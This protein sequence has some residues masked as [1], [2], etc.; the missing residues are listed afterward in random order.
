MRIGQTIVVKQNAN[1]SEL[2]RAIEAIIPA[3]TKQAAS[4]ANRY[5]GKNEAETCKK[6]FDYLKNNIN[7]KA[8]GT[9]QAVRLPSGLMRTAQGDCKSYSVFTSAIL[10]N[11]GIPHKLV[12]ASYDPKDPTPTHI[13]VMT[14]SGCIIDAVYG[15]FNAEKKATYKKYK[16]MNIS[17]IA[18]MNKRRRIGNMGRY[19]TG[20]S[21]G[22]GAVTTG[23]TWAKN[24]GIWNTI[25]NGVKLNFYKNLVL[26]P[27]IG[28]REIIKALLRKNSG[29]FANAL[30]KVYEIARANNNTDEFR[31][32]RAM[33]L[34]WLQ[35]GGNPDDLRVAFQEGN[36]KT[37]TGAK[38]NEVLKKAK[39]GQ[40]ISVG[41]AIA[42][43]VS[44]LFGKK[45]D[46]STGKVIG[47]TGAEELPV[48]LAT[49]PVWLPILREVVA[50]LGGSFNVGGAQ[51]A[52]GENV[53]SQ[54]GGQG[55]EGTQSKFA[56]S[57]LL[58]VL[59]IGG[60]AAAYFILKPTKK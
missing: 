37:P 27:Y 40:S 2:Q 57:G 51:P 24:L 29:G 4:I 3:A 56:Q 22:I 50:I 47:A 25:P 21:C 1:N 46:P 9:N 39:A 55:G 23:E 13:Y 60:A 18:G 20:G 19:G 58:P 44:A 16:D 17:Y 54:G 31:K 36:S 41:E 15:K 32:Y 8:D 43:A 53:D 14:K 7:Y 35:K 5:K 33:E 38:F 26:P 45:Y 10:S 6:I 30:A 52:T 12:Y 49:A 42:A 28:G 59:L 11:L 48:V 34:L